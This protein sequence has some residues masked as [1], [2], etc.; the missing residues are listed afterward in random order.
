[1][2]LRG[3]GIKPSTSLT[4]LQ[5][6]I[7]VL[8]SEIQQTRDEIRRNVQELQRLG[9]VA[10]SKDG[11]VFSTIEIERVEFEKILSNLDSLDSRLEKSFYQQ[12]EAKAQ[13]LFNLQTLLAGG[14]ATSCARTAVAPIDRIKIFLQTN[15]D[16]KGIGNVFRHVIQKEGWRGLWRGNLVN[17][18]RVF[19]KGGLQFV[20]YDDFKKRLKHIIGNKTWGSKLAC[21]VVGA[22]F[23]TTALHPIDLM[24]LRVMKENSLTIGGFLKQTLVQEG[25]FRGFYRGY[26]S[27]LMGTAPFFSIQ[28]ATTDYLKERYEVKPGSWKI[29]GLGAVGSV[30]ASTIC[31][32]TD[33]IQKKVMSA[34]KAEG[35]TIPSIIRGVRQHPFNSPKGVA[36]LY[37]GFSMNCLKVAP[38]TG[39]RFWFCDLIL[40]KALGRGKD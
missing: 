35:V 40:A 34:G 11:S 16:V 39:L 10:A 24:R 12:R 26:L 17:C 15:T 8:E 20:V 7:A 22:L 30:F 28:F 21:A 36:G 27:S 18:S 32:P 5:D 9:K 38:Q 2:V 4:E 14:I 1:M 6:R 37:R 33:T 29:I 3:S 19:F 13:I 31:Y 23:V 25:F